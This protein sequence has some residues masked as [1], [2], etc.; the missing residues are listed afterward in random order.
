[1]IE[2]T[3]RLALRIGAVLHFDNV[4]ETG[5]DRAPLVFGVLAL[6]LVLQVRGL[7]RVEE[8]QRGVKILGA[9]QSGRADTGGR[10]FSRRFG[11]RCGQGQC[12]GLRCR[13]AR[14]LPGGEH[15]VV[16]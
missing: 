11:R 13:R 12:A 8:V 2:Y 14:L 15:V 10:R 1:M 4:E 16:A 6:Q 9:D 5:E 3:E 7:S